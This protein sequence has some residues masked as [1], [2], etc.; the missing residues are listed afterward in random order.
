MKLPCPHCGADTSLLDRSADEIKAI[1]PVELQ[2]DFEEP[3]PPLSSSGSPLMSS[4]ASKSSGPS[5]QGQIQSPVAVD[6]QSQ[7]QISSTPQSNITHT[8]PPDSSIEKLPEDQETIIRSMENKL[9]TLSSDMKN[10]LKSQKVI[11]SFL[12]NI[13]KKITK[14]SEK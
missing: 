11:E 12:T 5:Q 8:G 7:S 2:G 6:H 10:L 1:V 9:N 13:N 4:Q 3:P 14:L